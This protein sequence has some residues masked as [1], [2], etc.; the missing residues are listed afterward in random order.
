MK[1][2]GYPKVKHSW[3]AIVMGEPVTPIVLMVSP[4]HA[5]MILIA[6][7]TLAEVRLQN[8][9]L[10]STYLLAVGIRERLGVWVDVPGRLKNSSSRI[11]TIAAVFR[12]SYRLLH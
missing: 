9:Q 10:A 6:V 7:T 12:G 2:V 4:A 8:Q 5:K 1:L 3:L 11:L